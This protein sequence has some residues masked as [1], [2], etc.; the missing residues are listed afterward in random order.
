MEVEL[1]YFL[2][3]NDLIDKGFLGIRFIG[4]TVRMVAIYDS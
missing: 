4:I 2:S 3:S 1:R